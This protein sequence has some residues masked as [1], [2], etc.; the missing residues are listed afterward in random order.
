[1]PLS[2]LSAAVSYSWQGMSYGVAGSRPAVNFDVLSASFGD[3]LMPDYIGVAVNSPNRDESDTV[4]A[5]EL[6]NTATVE[7]VLPYE[8]I[9]EVDDEITSTS[10]TAGEAPDASGDEHLGTYG[11]G[12]RSQLPRSVR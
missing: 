2:L 4:A 7:T 5:G 10:L 8:T 11:R 9:A 12:G 1:M 6:Q 3:G